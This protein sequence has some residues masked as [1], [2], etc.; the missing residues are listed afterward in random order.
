MRKLDV[1]LE[2][3]ISLIFWRVRQSLMRILSTRGSHRAMRRQSEAMMDAALADPL[4]EVGH[5]QGPGKV[6]AVV[7]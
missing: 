5:M 3:P 1:A 7:R 2:E 4:A 6:A